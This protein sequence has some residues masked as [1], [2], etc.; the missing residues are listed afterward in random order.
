[1][2]ERKKSELKKLVTRRDFLAAG[3]A[4][5]AAGALSACTPKTVTNNITE[6][7]TVT[8]TAPP[9]TPVAVTTTTTVP[10]K[11]A[12]MN[13][14][15][16]PKEIDKVPLVPTLDAAT[17]KTKS[18]WVIGQKGKGQGILTG[19]AANMKAAGYKITEDGKAAFFGSD[20]P[21]L[22]DRAAKDAAAIIFGVGD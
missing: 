13:P 14:R 20:E 4:V 21:A 12:T 1:M 8:S 18:I 2:T 11:F 9:V 19:I 16:Y 5:I 22:W 10:A 17:L 7:K 15:G 3:G 6:T